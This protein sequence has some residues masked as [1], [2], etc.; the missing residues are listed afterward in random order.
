MRTVV[1]LPHSQLADFGRSALSVCFAFT[2]ARRRH[3][4]RC[5][6]PLTQKPYTEPRGCKRIIP[7]F[8][9][10]TRYSLPMFT[11]YGCA[12]RKPGTDGRARI[13]H[14]ATM[15]SGRTTTLRNLLR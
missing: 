1:P 3:G 4:L 7:V 12:D 14:C 5:P 10:R 9:V 11:L 2:A 8:T 15:F 6:Y 13:P